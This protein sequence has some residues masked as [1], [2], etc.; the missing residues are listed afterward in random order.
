MLV[1]GGPASRVV[2]SDEPVSAFQGATSLI[3][4]DLQT[5]L[6]KIFSSMFRPIVLT[7]FAPSPQNLG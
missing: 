1:Q 7:T 5:L 6:A 2:L 4:S 3:F